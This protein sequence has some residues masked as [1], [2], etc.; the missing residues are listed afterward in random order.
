MNKQLRWL[1]EK[2]EL[3]LLR[4]IVK[5]YGHLDFDKLFDDIEEV[6]CVMNEHRIDTTESKD[7]SVSENHFFKHH[8][9]FR[10]FFDKENEWYDY[11][12]EEYGVKPK[13][14]KRTF[15]LK[16]ELTNR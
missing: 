8:Y 14:V 1:D 5:E 3:M 7:N 11:Y 6:D 2:S 15:D 16:T 12:E 13:G 4:H 9:M 10:A